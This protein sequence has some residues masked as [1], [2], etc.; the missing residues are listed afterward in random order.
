MSEKPK[1]TYEKTIWENSKTI[2]NASNMNKI[3]S[4]IEQVVHAI[5]DIP[6]WVYETPELPDSVTV[7]EAEQL[8]EN[9]IALH[10]SPTNNRD[11]HSIKSITEFTDNDIDLISTAD[12]GKILGVEERNNKV[13]IVPRSL[14]SINNSEFINDSRYVNDST[15]AKEIGRIQR[16]M[17]DAKDGTI[18]GCELSIDDAVDIRTLKINTGTFIVCGRQIRVDN[19][20]QIPFELSDWGMYYSVGVI[21]KIDLTNNP[22]PTTFEDGEIRLVGK[23]I[24]EDEITL[25]QEDVNKDGNIYETLIMEVPMPMTEMDFS[26]FPRWEKVIIHNKIVNHIADLE[27]TIADLESYIGYTDPDILGVEVDFAN[28]RF[29]RLAGAVGLEAG[30][31]FNQFPMYNRR[32]CNLTDE[33]IVTAYWGDEAY[34]ETGFTEQQI[35]I[36]DPYSGVPAIFIMAGTPVQVMVEQKPF[37]YKV[38][39]LERTC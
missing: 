20:I 24:P 36:G 38:V 27:S 16:E 10:K 33:G 35:T 3:Q 13:K 32:R 34:T 6:E 30:E 23:E 18:T 19:E 8:V 28:N 26:L 21:Y 4:G 25:V 39:P 22:N 7:A 31:D 37:Y 2:L 1:I 9:E 11:A 17:Y 14:T 29:T 15:F 12:E 5:Q